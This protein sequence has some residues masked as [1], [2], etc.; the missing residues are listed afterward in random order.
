MRVSRVAGLVLLLSAAGLSGQTVF[1][2][3][4][5]EPVSKLPAGTKPFDCRPF[6]AVAFHVRNTG[7]SPAVLQIEA[8]DAAGALTKGTLKLRP[9]ADFAAAF[10]LNSPDPLEM[11]MR[12]PAAVPGYR[13]TSSDYRKVDLSRVRSIAVRLPATSKV[14]ISDVKLIPGITYD[15]IVDPLGQFALGEWP[16]KLKNENEFAERRAAEEAAI[17][18]NPRLPDRDEYGGWTAGPTLQ[19]TGFFRAAKRDGKWWLV[20]PEG[21]L[22]LSFGAN[23]ITTTEGDTITEGRESMFQWLPARDDALA[24][25]YRENRDWEALGL[26]IKHHMGQSYNFYSANLQRKYGSNWYEKWEDMTLARLPAWG[27]NTIGNWSDKQ[28]YAAKKIAYTVT[29]DPWPASQGKMQFAEVASGNDYW[30]RMADPFDPR[31]AK[32]LEQ[33]TRE[34]ALAH[35]DDPWCLGYFIDNEMSWGSMKDDRSRYGLALGTLALTAGSPAKRT[36]VKNLT[37]KYGDV[38]KLNQSWGTNLESWQV[39]LDRPLKPAGDLVAGMKDD[40]R[41]FSKEFARQYFRTVIGLLKKYDSNHLY[42]GPRFAWHTRE[43]VEACGEL[44]DVVSFN[45]YRPKVVASEWTVLQR[46]D[47]PVLIGEF[48]MGALDRGMFHTGLVPS[49]DQAD[50]AR[51]YQEYIRSVVDN[52]LMVGCHYFK[53]ADEPLTG[54]PGDG[55]NYNIGMVSVADSPYPEFIE[56]AKAVHAEAYTRRAGRVSVGKIPA[57]AGR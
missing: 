39:L 26:K 24:G 7:N 6:G 45:I 22:F 14:S 31:Y 1:L 15:K 19:A 42:L 9:E 56:A 4:G 11:G 36:F 57:G 16:G 5:Q 13:L 20:T 41:A 29:I 47:K 2:I 8:K 43:S 46:I 18:A 12:G 52:P 21:H 49:E 53:Y 17:A 44:C 28:L 48:H 40:L 3:P 55:E 35:K 23:S 54:R 10:P 27:M 50:R 25:H 33:G 37:A 34:Q 30:K 32:A 51:M 38:A